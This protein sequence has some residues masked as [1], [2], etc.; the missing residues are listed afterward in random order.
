M[1]GK[2]S[3]MDQR[4]EQTPHVPPTRD[5]RW[6]AAAFMILRYEKRQALLMAHRLDRRDVLATAKLMLSRM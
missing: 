3:F 2:S 6:R 4:D 1:T 5:V